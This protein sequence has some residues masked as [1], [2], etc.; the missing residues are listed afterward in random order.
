MLV[1]IS[2]AFGINDRYDC[3]EY[4]FDSC[5]VNEIFTFRTLQFSVGVYDNGSLRPCRYNDIIAIAWLKHI[6]IQ[7]MYVIII[8]FHWLSNEIQHV[9]HSW[10]KP[11]VCWQS[12]I[13]VYNLGCCHMVIVKGMHIQ[14]NKF[15][16]TPIIT[17][18][19]DNIHNLDQ[20]VNET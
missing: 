17:T 12:V 7:F 13:P 20:S 1:I 10:C 2:Q 9:I 8:P 3:I 4:R 6:E 18:D 5:Y 11:I 15:Q 16:L 14:S 19:Y